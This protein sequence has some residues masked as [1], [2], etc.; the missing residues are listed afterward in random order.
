MVQATAGKTLGS[1]R[2]KTIA[3]LWARCY[4]YRENS[5]AV[6]GATR[7]WMVMRLA[8]R[9]LR[10]RAG[11]TVEGEGD[12]SRQDHDRQDATVLA[13]LL[14]ADLAPKTSAPGERARE[15]RGPLRERIFCVRL[16]HDREEPDVRPLSGAGGTVEEAGLSVR[17]GLSNS[18]PIRFRRWIA[19]SHPPCPVDDSDVG[20]PATGSG[21]I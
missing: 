4:R 7:N 12:R 11:A 16:A 8:G 15:L 17:Q 2:V 10:R 1:G 9:H 19:S 21:P 14:R 3:S 18:R 6:V 5:H 13:H 20:N